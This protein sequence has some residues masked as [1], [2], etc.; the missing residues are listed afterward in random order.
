MKI[1]KANTSDLEGIRRLYL[2]AF[3]DEEN[4][5]VANLACELLE[6]ATTPE[7]IS[8]AAE[9]GNRVL[10]HVAFSP[11]HS[12]QAG[13]LFAYLLAPLAVLPSHQKQGAGKK[14]IEEG[15]KELTQ[16]KT[17]TVLVYG[18]PAYYAQ[19]G[20]KPELAKSYLPPYKLTYPFGWLAIDLQ[21]SS[22]NSPANDIECVSPLNKP[23]LW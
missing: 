22:D 10:G 15:F 19:F 13:E 17:K 14:L 4:V 1:R 6:A 11:V 16:R 5:L 3:G 21:G 23:E 2:E 9:E 7:T 12:K 18:D 20:F 8:L